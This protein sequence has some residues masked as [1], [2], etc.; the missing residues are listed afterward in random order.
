[1]CA[2][3]L[4]NILEMSITSQDVHCF[5]FLTISI[6][7]ICYIGRQF[8]TVQKYTYRGIQ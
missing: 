6:V 7:K 2:I 5:E 8:V 3:F 1:M 4:E